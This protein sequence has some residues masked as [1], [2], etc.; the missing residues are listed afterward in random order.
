MPHWVR[1]ER[2]FFLWK[3]VRGDFVVTTRL[4]AHGTAGATPS[5][6]WSLAGLLVRRAIPATSHVENWIGWTTGG[7]AGA[8][9]FERKTTLRSV[10]TLNL[11]QARTGWLQLRIARVGPPFLL[12]HRYDDG[13]WTLDWTY[14]R[15]DLPQSLQV[16]LDA[17][18]GWGDTH[19]DLVA[20]VDFVH[21]AATGIPARLRRRVASGKASPTR[22]LPY[23]T[24]G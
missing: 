7:V 16:G 5:A 15:A 21:F 22:V 3:P 19:A 6:D 13:P 11:L 24:R 14:R 8:Q 9:V 2:A 10:S 12:L 17:Q 1:T 18:S 20:D 23:V 4:R